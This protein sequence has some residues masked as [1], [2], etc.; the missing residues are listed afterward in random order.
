MKQL[1]VVLKLDEENS[2]K[3]ETIESSAEVGRRE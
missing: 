2:S 3:N 1:K